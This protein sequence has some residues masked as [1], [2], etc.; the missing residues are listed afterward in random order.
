MSIHNEVI[1][2][3]NLLRFG[4]SLTSLLVSVLS[5]AFDISAA[6]RVEFDVKVL[7]GVVSRAFL[8]DLEWVSERVVSAFISTFFEKQ[9]NK[10]TD[11]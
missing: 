6:V 3:T 4:K 1:P 8:A 2:R 11:A 5:R 9:Y 7:G 10:N